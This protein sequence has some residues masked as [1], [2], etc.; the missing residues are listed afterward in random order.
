MNTRINRVVGTKS[1]V[2]QQIMMH[3]VCDL[4][5]SNETDFVSSVQWTSS[6]CRHRKSKLIDAKI[7]TVGQISTTE[8][9]TTPCALVEYVQWDTLVIIL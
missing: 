8:N 1:R 5:Q 6:P 9:D 7:V 4:E 3:R 2:N